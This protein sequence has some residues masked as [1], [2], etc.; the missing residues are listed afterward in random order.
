MESTTGGIAK[1]P[2]VFK[3]N[4]DIRKETLDRIYWKDAQYTRFTGNFV[5]YAYLDT[6]EVRPVTDG[7][8]LYTYT[9]DKSTH[10]GYDIERRYTPD[11]VTR[12][13]Y[14]TDPVLWN[15]MWEGDYL[16]NFTLDTKL[17]RVAVLELAKETAIAEYIH[18]DRHM[19]DK[20]ITP[21]LQY[22][23]GGS[24][25]MN[26]HSLF[27][28]GNKTPSRIPDIPEADVRIIHNIHASEYRSKTNR[29]WDHLMNQLAL[30]AKMD[31][32]E[33]GSDTLLD[34]YFSTYV[35]YSLGNFSVGT[36][37]SLMHITHP[38]KTYSSRPFSSS[39]R[40]VFGNDKKL[41][42][43]EK[44]VS[45]ARALESLK[46]FNPALTQM[47]EEEV[48]DSLYDNASHMANAEIDEIFAGSPEYPSVECLPGDFH[49][50]PLRDKIEL[51]ASIE[52]AGN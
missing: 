10:Y 19:E 31:G 28:Y 4:E 11:D 37:M 2:G 1:V 35:P 17:E 42:Y 5:K 22:F 51:L 3:L 41:A 40:Y 23:F 9:H 34:R 30:V 38:S 12:R 33:D 15:R 29:G 26:L 46:A 7:K 18:N 6:R 24:P 47:P 16:E 52:K 32:F 25:G 36:K 27:K 43:D 13:V 8:D 21:Q 14:E 20:Y 49:E 44:D 48:I 39:M 45:S 50:I